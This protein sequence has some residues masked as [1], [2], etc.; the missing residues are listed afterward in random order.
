MIKKTITQCNEL[1]ATENKLS[2]ELQELKTETAA[3]RGQLNVARSSSA[4]CADA[5]SLYGT[6][7]EQNQKHIE[8]INSHYSAQWESFE[9]RCFKWTARE[10]VVHFRRIAASVAV[11]TK[12]STLKS[13]DV[14]EQSLVLFPRFYCLHFADD[15]LSIPHE[16]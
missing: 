6:F 14:E 12:D 15:T 9:S 2:A 7:K 5:I 8:T 11:D 3:V 10:L 13:D 4:D 16:H 1:I